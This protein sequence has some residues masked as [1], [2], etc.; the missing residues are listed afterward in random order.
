MIQAIKDSGKDVGFKAAGGVRN[1]EDAQIYLQLASNIMGE[2]WVNETH[3]RFGA[4]S[5]L[6]NLLNTL[7]YSSDSAGSGSY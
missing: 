1:A 7:G 6:G 4:S 3:F 5:L 2:H